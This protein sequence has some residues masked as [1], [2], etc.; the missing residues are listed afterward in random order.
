LQ[1][2][3]NVIDFGMD[4]RQAVDAPRIHHQWFPDRI[5]F[6]GASENQAA[7]DK[8]RAMGH[9]VTGTRQGDAHTICVD[10]KTGEITG[11]EDRRIM[12]KAAGF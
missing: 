4:A 5:R 6:E 8:L 11:A 10:P 3:V 1:V 9:Q 12:G 7:V 2:V